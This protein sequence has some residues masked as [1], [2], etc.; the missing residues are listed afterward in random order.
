EA[1]TLPAAAV[2]RACRCAHCIEETTGRPL[3]D[4]DSVPE[5]IYPTSIS[6]MGNYAVAVAWSDGHSSIYP[7]DALLELAG[8]GVA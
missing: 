5:D 4:P 1:H 8:A 6:A 3:L 7:Y 2:R